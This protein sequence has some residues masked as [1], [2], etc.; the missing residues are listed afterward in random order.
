MDVSSV[1]QDFGFL[2]RLREARG[3]PSAPAPERYTHLLVEVTRRTQER[4]SALDEA[5]TR[6][7]A[8]RRVNNYLR[9]IEQERYFYDAATAATSP[10]SS[11]S[12]SS[13]AHSP[14][15]A[16][17]FSEEVLS[18]VENV[19]DQTLSDAAEPLRQ[20]AKRLKSHVLVHA[21]NNEIQDNQNGVHGWHNEV[22]SQY[23]D[24][25]AHQLSLQITHQNGT[26]ESLSYETQ[27]L[28]HQN[29]T[30]N[31]QLGSQLELLQRQEQTVE[32]LQKMR[33]SE[34]EMVHT[35]SENLAILSG[36][37]SQ[38]SQ[39]AMNLPQAIE[40]VVSNAVQRHVQVGLHDVM[41][42]QQQAMLSL[43]HQESQRLQPLDYDHLAAK[44]AENIQST[45]KDKVD[46]PRV[47]QR[48][49]KVFRRILGK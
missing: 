36:I 48:I 38:M 43:V 40:E 3:D 33:A 14:V 1:L 28:G 37:I 15:D 12:A 44:V 39:L 23:I 24:S 8:A 13:S 18:I 4:D 21:R 27:V 26:N 6:R 41:Q 17:T 20:E 30:F 10:K 16:E 22:F 25:F 9:S 46:K 32:S 2:T 19:A 11:S 45:R 31:Q 35:S 42:A 7:E 5:E 49:C 29:H 34:S 47:G